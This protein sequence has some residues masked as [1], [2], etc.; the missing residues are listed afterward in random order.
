[1]SAVLV[2]NIPIASASKKSDALSG[3]GQNVSI[4][5]RP[6]L[7]AQKEN[8]MASQLARRLSRAQCEFLMLH[9]DGAEVPVH[10][11]YNIVNPNEELTRRAMLRLGLIRHTPDRKSTVYTAH[12]QQIL[13][14]ILGLWAVALQRAGYHLEQQTYALDIVLEQANRENIP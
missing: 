1:M 7:C 12:G 8:P 4:I 10:R 5:G 6:V 9:I 14:E 13:C 2:R 3:R 11:M